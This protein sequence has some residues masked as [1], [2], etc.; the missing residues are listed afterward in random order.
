MSQ[1]VFSTEPQFEEAVIKKLQQYGWEET[2]LKNPT[3]K[4]SFKTG[5]I[6]YMRITATVTAL[7]AI[8]SLRGKCNRL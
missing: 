7:T 8:H 5:P 1:Q 3:E 2:V 4:I 6:F